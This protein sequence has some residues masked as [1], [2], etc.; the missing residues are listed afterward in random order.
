MDMQVAFADVT[1]IPTEIVPNGI[2]T[3]HYP[4]DC[5]VFECIVL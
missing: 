5:I 3:V 4:E 1:P 2:C